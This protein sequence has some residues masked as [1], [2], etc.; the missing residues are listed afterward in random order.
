MNQYKEHQLNLC[1]NNCICANLYIYIVIK[2]SYI[3]YIITIITI[4]T[5]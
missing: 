5:S 3:Y 1:D 4:E 2:L